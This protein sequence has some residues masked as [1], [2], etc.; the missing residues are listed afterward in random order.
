MEF[1][2]NNDCFQHWLFPGNSYSLDVKFNQNGT[3]I[4][5][6]RF[7]IQAVNITDTNH[8]KV[9]VRDLRQIC[10]D[11]PLNVSVFHPYFVFFDQFE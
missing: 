5:A 8:E 3:R 9:M 4:E 1:D 2:D 10:K 6:S 11:S 7:L